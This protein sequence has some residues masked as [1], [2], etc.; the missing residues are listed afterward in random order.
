MR[1]SRNF[2]ETVRWRQT[3][4][5]YVLLTLM[6]GVAL[7]AV[8]AAMVAPSIAFEIR[9]DREEEL[10]H[11]GVQ[12]SRA[13]RLYAK[14]THG[15]PDRFEQLQNRDGRRYIRRLYKDPVTGRDF[16][17]V[18]TADIAKVATAAGLTSSPGQTIA[19]GSS[20]NL[21]QPP[22]AADG[23]TPDT[24]AKHPLGEIMFGVV[25]T[26]KHRTIRE[27]DHKNRY[28]QWLFFYDPNY[29]R[30]QQIN[31]PTSLTAAPP[32]QTG[33]NIGQPATQTPPQPQPPQPP[34]Q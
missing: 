5:G 29:D 9:R 3:E 19:G 33:G 31:G 15:F 22:V 7:L 32:A 14:Q 34:Q 25:S 12:Y 6:L 13:V 8:A 24:T 1:A 20:G 28:N 2:D 10:I 11:R 30:G 16:R 21:T 27:F 26:S 23:L 4:R 17:P 18:Y